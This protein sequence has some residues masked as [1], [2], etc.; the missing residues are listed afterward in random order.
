MLAFHVIRS[1]AR[2]D[3][4]D[5]EQVCSY[6]YIAVKN[7]IL[8]IC[9]QSQHPCLHIDAGK[10]GPFNRELSISETAPFLV[11]APSESSFT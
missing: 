10:V 11:Q 1:D 3:L 2:Y 7:H 9:P 6:S 8:S 5:K 4:G